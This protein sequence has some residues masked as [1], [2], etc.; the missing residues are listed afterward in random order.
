LLVGAA[1]IGPER[2]VVPAGTRGALAA[3]TA[4]ETWLVGGVGRVLPRPLYD[5]LAKSVGGEDGD[6]EITLTLFDRIAGPKGVER[7]YDAASRVDCPIVPELL[8]RADD[9]S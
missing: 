3:I 7:T 8:R 4:K 2:A 5:A 9:V 1:A 6:E